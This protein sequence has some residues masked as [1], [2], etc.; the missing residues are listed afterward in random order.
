MI[1]ILIVDDNVQ[2]REALRTELAA[3]DHVSVVGEAGDGVA[4]VQLAQSLRPD[5]V[6]MDV[7]MARL[8]G[9][10]A[11]RRIRAL[12]PHT[13]VVGMSFFSPE[14]IEQAMRS[15]GADLFLPKDTLGQ[16]LLPAVAR[17][18]TRRVP[19]APESSP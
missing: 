13:V 15:A 4:A 5:V 11:T 12:L 1:G 9:V 8:D 6:L 10:A 2:L 14:M 16:Q 7:N 19:I 17:M 18:I 3:N